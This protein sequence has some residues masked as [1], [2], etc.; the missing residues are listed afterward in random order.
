MYVCV[1]IYIGFAQQGAAFESMSYY[2]CAKM[3]SN[4]RLRVFVCTCSSKTGKEGAFES[5]CM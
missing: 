4:G 3:P 5:V 2:E 1:C